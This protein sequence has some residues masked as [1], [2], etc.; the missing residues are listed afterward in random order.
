MTDEELHSA[1]GDD[2]RAKATR[3]RNQVLHTIGNLTILPP[4]TNSWVSN[5][6]WEEKK[7]KILSKSLLPINPG[8]LYDAETWDECAIEKRGTAPL[9]KGTWDLAKSSQLNSRL[10]LLVVSAP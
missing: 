5:A 2:L 3:K 9:R 7:P 8:L 6:S 4:G 1:S 10:R